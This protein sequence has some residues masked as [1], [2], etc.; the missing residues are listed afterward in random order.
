M[1]TSAVRFTFTTVPFGEVFSFGL[2]LSVSLA[3]FDSSGE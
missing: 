2:A 1:V 3:G